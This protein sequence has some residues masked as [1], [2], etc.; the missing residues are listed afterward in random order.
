MFP[1]FF[2]NLVLCGSNH[3]LVWCA[4]CRRGRLGCQSVGVAAIP[5]SLLLCMLRCWAPSC[6]LRG[7]S[8]KCVPWY[9]SHANM[10]L[11]QHC[12]YVIPHFY[13]TSL[14][15]SER[16]KLGLVVKLGYWGS[17]RTAR[18]PHMHRARAVRQVFEH[19]LQEMVHWERSCRGSGSAPGIFL[20][21]LLTR[22]RNL[23]FLCGPFPVEDM[24]DAPFHKF[25]V[26]P[27]I[28]FFYLLMHFG[29]GIFELSPIFPRFQPYL[30]IFHPSFL[31][32]MGNPRR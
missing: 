8:A 21:P 25:F 2:G 30:P 10:R 31:P 13:G 22:S 24:G 16:V 15:Q 28:F 11:F 14:A 7:M 1:H 12:A 4:G 5:F 18:A 6:V 3:K 17:I 9:V 23:G 20:G 32:T 29:C 27:T 19:F 26:Q